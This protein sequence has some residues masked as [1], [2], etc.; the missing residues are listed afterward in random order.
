MMKNRILLSVSFLLILPFA[1]WLAHKGPG[2]STVSYPPYDLAAMSTP[3]DTTGSI[4]LNWFS[5]TGDDETA[6]TF[7]VYGILRSDVAMGPFDEVGAVSF[8]SPRASPKTRQFKDTTAVIGSSYFYKVSCETLDGVVESNVYGPVE[9]LAQPSGEEPLEIGDIISFPPTQL[10]VF[11]TPDDNGGSIT[12]EWKIS[13]NDISKSMMFNGYDIFRS[14][15]QD[16]PY[17]RVI[18]FR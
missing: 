6:Q 12:L 17:E 9:S 15:A 13:P 8:E 11:D 1:V 7:P 18:Q 3:G 16:G 4:T 14:A 10:R 2:E 5:L